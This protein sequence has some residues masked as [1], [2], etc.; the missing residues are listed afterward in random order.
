MARLK[1]QPDN[2]LIAANLGIVVRIASTYWRRLPAHLRS[3]YDIEDLVSEIVLH[4]LQKQ[5][6]YRPSRGAASNF[7]WHVSENC[8]RSLLQHHY[9][10]K[11]RG[12]VYNGGLFSGEREPVPASW[13]HHPQSPRDLAEA[14]MAM[15][16]VL[17][18]A[19]PNLIEA[20]WV[21]KTFRR[22]KSWSPDVMQELY[23][24]LRRH[25]VSPEQLKLVL[26]NL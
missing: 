14:F 11:R 23:R 3:V 18:D 15:E 12:T 22:F 5:S 16:R 7:V 2:D 26:V 10:K 17:A 1:L 6:S 13:H 9:Q 8:C 21:F 25:S 4:L 20:L 24:L 19:S